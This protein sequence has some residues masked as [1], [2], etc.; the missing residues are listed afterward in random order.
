MNE[1]GY[2]NLF[3]FS[4]SQ[5]DVLLCE[6]MFDADQFN[7]FTRYSIDVRD[8]LPK[9]IT[10]MQKTLSR[11]NYDTYF[12]TGRI[13]TDIDVNE[14]VDDNDNYYDID[15][16]CIEIQ[17]IIKQAL[18]RLEAHEKPVTSER[19]CKALSEYYRESM[20]SIYYDKEKNQ[21]W[22]CKV[23]FLMIYAVMLVTFGEPGSG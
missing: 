3:R 10:K 9:A 12:L 18:T 7:P 17:N 21:F 6:K 19:V 20:M 23:H 8:I 14:P 15:D 16:K 4:L 5:G 1:K 13:D 22:C 2:S 11:R